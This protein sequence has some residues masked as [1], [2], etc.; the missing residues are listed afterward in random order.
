MKILLFNGPPSSGKDEA[1]QTVYDYA[2]VNHPILWLRMSHPIKLAFNGMME[3]SIDNR[4]NSQWDKDKEGQI[5]YLKTS[6]RQWQIDFSEKFMKSYGEDVFVRLY[7]R[8]IEE[9]KL[10]EGPPAL[11]LTPDCGFEVE[12]N[13]LLHRYGSAVYL[14]RIHRPGFDFSRDS[15]SYIGPEQRGE[16][17][18][19]VF[20]IHNDG[21]LDAFRGKIIA[22][23]KDI[24]G[25]I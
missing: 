10:T 13:G 9:H 22:L 5:A 6:Y 20:D 7:E 21:P 16:A 19:R 15:R 4:G 2:L 11:V 24:L 17:N 1:A 12:Y 25:R 8:R 18:A 3:T 23:T 14:I